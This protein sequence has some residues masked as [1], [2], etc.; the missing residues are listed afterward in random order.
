MRKYDL[1]EYVACAYIVY[2]GDSVFLVPDETPWRTVARDIRHLCLRSGEVQECAQR[3]R[4][5]EKGAKCILGCIHYE[6][7]KNETTNGTRELLSG[8]KSWNV[9]SVGLLQTRANRV[10]VV[11]DENLYRI[12]TVLTTVGKN[13]VPCAQ[14][15]DAVTRK[16][17]FDVA[18]NSYF[19]WYVHHHS[20]AK[21]SLQNLC[22]ACQDDSVRV[23]YKRLG[24]EYTRLLTFLPTAARS[25]PVLLGADET[26][27]DFDVSPDGTLLVATVEKD[28]AVN[29]REVRVYR[30]IDRLQFS[31]LHTYNLAC[32]YVS[33]AADGLTFA[34]GS[35]VP[36]HVAGITI[37]D[38]DV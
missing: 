23:A 35:G 25:A 8:T 27:I 3:N 22:V 20:S 34:L 16:V 5:R 18:R 17:G 4:L 28:N 13:R 2:R 7:Q 10:R 19:D 31:L 24:H 33:F 12:N 36:G 9:L 14:R 30:I 26:L 15:K 37:M 11:V 29:G 32:S 1:G 21:R 6:T 38:V